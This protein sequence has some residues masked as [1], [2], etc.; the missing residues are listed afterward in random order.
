MS[1]CYPLKPSK[2]QINWLLV[3]QTITLNNYWDIPIFDTHHFDLRDNYDELK[4]MD[5]FDMSMIYSMV[6]RASYGGMKNDVNMIH[7]YAD[8]W[9]KR[10]ANKYADTN[11]DLKLLALK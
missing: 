3:V 4:K 5:I 1:A 10:L 11:I 9:F 7:Y 2:L 8:L 6:F